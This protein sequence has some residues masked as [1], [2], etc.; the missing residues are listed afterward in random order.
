MN[1]H[2]ASRAEWRREAALLQGETYS[3]LV[4]A[5]LSF[6]TGLTKA[7]LQQGATGQLEGLQALNRT[8]HALG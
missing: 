6:F 3:S 1:E 4:L 7:A 5:P 8:L 2:T